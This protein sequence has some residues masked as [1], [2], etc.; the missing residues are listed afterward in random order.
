MFFLFRNICAHGKRLR[1]VW[2]VLIAF[3]FLWAGAF[4]WI[5]RSTAGP[6]YGF[7]ANAALRSF[8]GILMVP[9]LGLALVLW[10]LIVG[11]AYAKGTGWRGRTGVALLPLI[12]FFLYQGTQFIFAFPTPNAYFEKTFG[13]PLPSGSR[14]VEV[15]HPTPG[16]VGKV[17]FTLI[18]SPQA[19]W[20]LIE[21]MH[22]SRIHYETNWGAFTRAGRRWALKERKDFH[23][24]EKILPGGIGNLVLVD[25]KMERMIVVRE[26]LYAK[27][28]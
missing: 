13:V 23:Q 7:F 8:C 22:V 1:F 25:G 12:L 19:A 3:I 27:A 6:G 20:T 10:L 18:I 14:V 2:V 5:A 11:V 21:S 28:D 4:C 9:Y 24:Y 15:A 26:P 17:E 16:D